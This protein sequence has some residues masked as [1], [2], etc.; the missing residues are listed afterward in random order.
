MAVR[1]PQRGLVKGPSFPHC[2]SL[3]PLLLICRK[4]IDHMC[5]GLFLGSIPLISVCFK[6]ML[7]NT[8]EIRKHAYD[9]SPC[10]VVLD[11]ALAPG[12]LCGAPWG[13]LSKSRGREAQSMCGQSLHSAKRSVLSTHVQHGQ[14]KEQ[15]QFSVHGQKNQ[16]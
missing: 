12:V 14:W 1:F 3:A 16:F 8:F 15:S 9:A 11:I 5:V 7:R 4:L 2:V 6:C 10:P 13:T